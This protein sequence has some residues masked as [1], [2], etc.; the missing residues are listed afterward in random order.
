[1]MPGPTA[2]IIEKLRQ[3][4]RSRIEIRFGGCYL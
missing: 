2:Q 4:D 3:I 1:M